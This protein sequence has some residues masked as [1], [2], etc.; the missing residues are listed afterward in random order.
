MTQKP[1]KTCT[2]ILAGKDATIDGSTMIA[3]NEDGGE[4]SNPQ[5]FV[6][7]QPEDQPKTYQ[8]KISGV[9][10]ELPDHPLRYT[11]TPDFD[12]GQ[13][14]WGGSG[15][16]EENIA[17]TACETITS[18]AMTHAIDPLV[19][20]GI[21][22]EDML[23]IVLP[24]IHSAEEGV[25]RLGQLL[26]QYGT[27]ELN[28]IAFSDKDSVWYLETIG[29]HH[30][31][32]V[33]IP[34]DSY[35]VA[36]NRFN[37]DDFDFE[38]EDTHC[39]DDLKALIERYHLNPDHNR[40][41]L[42]HIFGSDT[43]KD[44]LYNNARTWYGQ[45]YFNQD[46]TV[47][48]PEYSDFPFIRRADFKISVADIKFVL[49]SHYQNTPYDMYDFDS[50]GQGKYRPIGINRNQEVHVLQ[51]RNDVSDAVAGIHW[52]AFGPN[53]FNALVPFYANVNDT[54]AA[55]KDTTTTYSPNHA[56]WL[57]RTLSTISD[58]NYSS[59]LD[60]RDHYEDDVTSQCLRVQMDTDD[61]IDKQTDVEK[62]LE[63]QNQQMA[64]IY[65][66]RSTEALG[67][68]VEKGMYLMHLRYNLD[69]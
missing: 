58:A 47:D 62:Y 48:D 31:A 60:I 53:T 45:R 19:K 27:Y 14:I 24:Y 38:S 15:I 32:A 65:M 6:V 39:S 44:T 42:R 21:G 37:I 50:E 67:A 13:G 3:R 59:Y 30:W 25:L 41:N 5:R 66:K 16:N 68:L 33:R 55:F 9:K 8:S 64:D 69:D 36:P 52:L 51:I 23:T 11:S 40:V 22:E 12:Q 7:V 46:N 2:T 18:N 43:V 4:Q 63:Q 17:M 26:E 56:Y 10:I 49:S 35:V 1:I 54:P 20:G 28:G 61:Q 57:S 34:D 29:G